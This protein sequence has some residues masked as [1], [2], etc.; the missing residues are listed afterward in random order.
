MEEVQDVVDGDRGHHHAGIDGA[1]DDTAQGIPGAVI[2][3]VEEVVGS[4]P[5]KVLGGSV[6]EP[7]IILV[8]DLWK[9]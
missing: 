7:G 8:N 6:V 5:G 2:E 4:G 9:C 1:T 3:P